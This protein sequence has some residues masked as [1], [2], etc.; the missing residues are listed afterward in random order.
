MPARQS[1]RGDGRFGEED[2]AL[3]CDHHDFVAVAVSQSRPKIG[4]AQAIQKNF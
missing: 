4:H 1:R 2:F 3:D